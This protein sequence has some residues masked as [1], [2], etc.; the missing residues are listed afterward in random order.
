MI[1]FVKETH[2]SNKNR[3]VLAVD[4]VDRLMRNFKD[5]PTMQELIQKEV[6]EIHI[7]GEND[8]ISKESNSMHNMFF[9]FRI[10]MAQSYTDAIRDNVKRSNE[11]KIQNGEYPNKAPIGYLNIRDE[12]GKAI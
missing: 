3:V 5:Y 1:D 4:K 6:A 11:Y 2:K 10:M 7:V 8:I 9:N 12:A